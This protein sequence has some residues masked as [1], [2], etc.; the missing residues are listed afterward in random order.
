MRPYCPASVS[1]LFVVLGAVALL[2]LGCGPAKAPAARPATTGP[3]PV[4][5]GAAEGSLR[6]A[7]VY[8][9][10]GEPLRD[11]LIV[12][13]TD[14]IG[15]ISGPAFRIEPELPVLS[16]AT[17]KSHIALTLDTVRLAPNR[18]AL[19]FAEELRGKDGRPFEAPEE[20]I[21]FDV[22][23]LREPVALALGRVDGEGALRLQLSFNRPME[24]EG[25]GEFLHASNPDGP[26]SFA[27]EPDSDGTA[28]TLVFEGAPRLPIEVQVAAGAPDTSGGVTR[29]AA[30]FKYPPQELAVSKVELQESDAVTLRLRWELSHPVHLDEVMPR[31]NASDATGAELACVVSAS[32][33]GRA[34]MVEAPA[35]APQPLQFT[36]APGLRATEGEAMMTAPHTVRYP[37]GDLRLTKAVWREDDEGAVL[38]LGFSEPIRWGQLSEYLTVSANAGGAAIPL[39]PTDTTGATNTLRLESVD[40]DVAIL[41]LS[42]RP[43]LQGLRLG[44]MSQPE[45]RE[46]RRASAPLGVDY[47]EWV[48]RGKDGVSLLINFNQVLDLASLRDAVR[49]EPE[50]ANLSIESQWGDAYRISGDFAPATDYVLHIAQKLK[51]ARGGAPLSSDYS[52]PLDTTPASTPGTGFDFEDRFYYPRR[53]AGVMP[54]VVRDL[55]RVEVRLSRLFPN[56]VAVALD[57]IKN[58]RTWEDFAG[59]WARELATKTVP[60]TGAKGKAV[61]VPLDLKEVIPDGVRGVF[62]VQLDPEPY[63]YTTKI[64]VWTNI[65]L[66]AQWVDSDLV[67]FAHDLFSI[68]PIAG[69]KVRVWSH[70]NQLMAEAVTDARGIARAQGMDRALGTPGVVICETEQDYSFL[71]LAPRGDD[72]VPATDDM[73][74]YDRSGYDAFLYADRNLYRPGE[75]VHA[76]W[77]ARTNYGDALANVPLQ[78]RMINPQGVEVRKEAVVLSA[79]GTG[80]LDIATEK[81]WPTG[82]YDFELKVPDAP[83]AAG[84]LQISIEDFVPNRIKA[85]VDL[86]EGPW[87][88]RTEHAIRLKAEQLFGG[89]AVRQK[90]KVSV[91]LRKGVYAAPQWQGYFFGNDSDY[92]PEVVPLGEKETNEQ[93]L[94][95]FSYVFPGGRKI[96]FPVQAVVRG[97]VLEAG[98]RPVVDTKEVLI[99]PSERL[100][101]LAL[102]TSAD[103]GVHVEVAAIQPDGTPAA[104][105]TVKVTLEREDWS[106]HVRR[107]SGYNEPNFTKRYVPIA[108]ESASTREGRASVDFDLGEYAWGYHRVRVESAGTPMTASRSFYKMWNGIETLDA[109]RP[110]L[111]KLVLNK[112]RYDVGEEAA[113]R[114][115]SPFDGKAVLVLQG[116]EMHE[117]LTEDVVHGAAVFRI[118][119]TGLMHP[120]VWAGVTV[121]H[122]APED[123]SQ[124]YPYS[125]FAMVNVPVRNPARRLEVALLDT[126]EEIRPGTELTVPLRTLGA[127]GGPR[128]AE[129]TVAAVDEGIHGILDYADP[130]PWNFLQRGRRPDH[131]R[132]HYYDRVAYDFDPAAIGGDLAARLAKR[133]ATIGENWIKP[134]ALWSGPVLTDSDGKGSVTFSVPEFTGQLRLVAVAADAT[135]TG[136]ASARVY[137]R[138]PYML[139]TAL[140]RFALPGDTFT[141]RATV[142]NTTAAHVTATVRWKAWGSL[143]GEGSETIAVPATQNAGVLAQFAAAAAGQGQIEWRVELQDVPEAPLQ[144]TAAL[145]VR[146]PAA[147]QSR[148]EM[149]EVAPGTSRDFGNAAF[150][151][152]ENVAMSITIGGDPALRVYNALKYLSNY[153]YGCVEQTV[154]QCFPLYVLRKS[155]GLM[156][157]LLPQQDR[158]EHRLKQGIDRLFSM[159]TSSGGLGYWPGSSETYRYGSIYALHF[160]ALVAQDHE[161]DLPEESYGRLQEFARRVCNEGG[162]TSASGLYLRAYAHFALALAGDQQAI[163]Q[164]GRFDNITLPESA[165]YLLASAI[166]LQGGG[167]EEAAAY[168][169]ARPTMPFT[170]FERGGTLNTPAR[171]AAVKLLALVSMGAQSSETAPLVNLLARHLEGQRYGNTQE[172]AFASA[173]LG[174]YF[175]RV[176]KVSE[177]RG[178]V[179]GPEGRREI[180]GREV[181]TL[182]HKGPGGAFTV[183]ND[184]S[185]PIIV[186]FSVSGLPHEPVREAASE[187]GLSLA[188]TITAMSGEAVADNKFAQGETYLVELRLNAAASLD[189]VVVADLLP[190]GFEIENPRLDANALAGA[191]VSKMVTP[192]YVDIRDD[193]LVIAFNRLGGG[194]SRYYY[195]VRAVTPCVAQHPAATAECMYDAGVR[196]ATAPGVVEVLAGP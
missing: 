116:G 40:E 13:F 25:I 39:E 78:L 69:A 88:P 82:K 60:V 55:D 3:A 176:G 93:G 130:D 62:G 187:G 151:D 42:F 74:A 92:K 101:G 20:P 5:A 113:L 190:A 56:N 48:E 24:T 97:E 46:V 112:E 99:L 192:N 18:Y 54:L 12:Y 132:A 128:S 81:T 189:N 104:S 32:G 150:V 14:E 61:K 111:I 8:P 153:P 154:S 64:V 94:A 161:F 90:A 173:A 114:V 95:E 155:A 57:A 76:R 29:A 10:P 166:A 149:S 26:L 194:E 66:L 103:G 102:T 107:F 109:P 16:T 118:P 21:T 86:E 45:L 70:K 152:D 174:A 41:N 143:S 146:P 188:R 63:N 36:L 9:L 191:P 49:F 122:R 84:Y 121:V 19:V 170:V 136:A 80:G 34:F 115:E 85:A 1:R 169:K 27:S 167:P 124:V 73:P 156:D 52:L 196:A 180:S 23:D 106:Y 123:R 75:T 177:C 138:R 17:G 59:Q 142:F 148:Q 159:Q 4:S 140:P 133:G 31:F 65:G 179:T 91:I 145:P 126:P 163:A 185:H 98:A 87:K 157:N 28:I 141:A 6:V 77:I 158:L 108:T 58:G 147:Y 171:D 68:A 175:N 184:G 110:S 165:R 137:V 100:L 119:L 96:N 67:V 162:D 195:V 83:Q 186:N 168:L 51:S 11:R 164:I 47:S 125:S 35:T 178:S 71:E 183:K 7:G 117:V 129:V 182:R 135:A 134:V 181:F 127:D 44:V 139:Q 144:Q 37:S 15:P 172:T 105:A 160:L 120:N 79:L 30:R 2:C 193:R 33:T 131:R 38:E 72:A 43:G 89:P 22:P 50:V 53:T